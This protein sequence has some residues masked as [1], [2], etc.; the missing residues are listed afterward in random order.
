MTTTIDRDTGRALGEGRRDAAHALLSARRAV[1]VRRGQRALLA[2]VLATGQATADDVRDAVELPP[3][4]DP[5]CL[6][7]VPGSLARAGIIRAGGYVRTCRPSAHA[8]PL[9]VWILADQAAA[10]RW[11]AAHPDV[12]DPIDADQAAEG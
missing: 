5:V 7:A 2:A 11:L 9:Q 6:G 4:I 10:E 1:Y 12:S 3:G 8:R